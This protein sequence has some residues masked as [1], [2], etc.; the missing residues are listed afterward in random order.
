[1]K[2]IFDGTHISTLLTWFVSIIENTFYIGKLVE[3]DKLKL[4]FIIFNFIA[5]CNTKTC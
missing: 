2:H 1:M 3:T 4:N 5:I